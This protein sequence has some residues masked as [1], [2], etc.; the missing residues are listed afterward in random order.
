MICISI[1]FAAHCA[2]RLSRERGVFLRL[3]LLDGQQILSEPLFEKA[4][5]TA[6]VANFSKA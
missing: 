1:S 5:L 6:E 3:N 4:F 2:R